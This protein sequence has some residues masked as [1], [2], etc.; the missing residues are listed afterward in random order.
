MSTQAFLKY[1]TSVETLQPNEEQSFEILA[2][3]FRV[4]RRESATSPGIRHG[5]FT[6][7]VTG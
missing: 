5:R 7:G 6:P 1:T 3:T 2:A 4:F